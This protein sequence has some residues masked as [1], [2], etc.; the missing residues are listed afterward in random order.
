ME[1]QL[2]LFRQVAVLGAGVMGAQIAA[3][4]ANAGFPVVL[5]D[6]A[7]DGPDKT[8]QV[9]AALKRLTK[10]KPAPLANLSTVEAIH[11]ATYE[12][13]LTLLSRC[14]LIIEAIAEREDLKKSLYEKIAPHI[15]DSAVLATNTSGLSIESLAQYLPEKMRERFCGVHFFNPPRYMRLVELIPHSKTHLALLN[16]LETCL[17]K[18]AG[19]SVVRAKD[20]PN[21]IA[22]RIGVFSALSIFAHATRL[23][24]PP[25]VV[26]ALTGLVI[27]RPKSATYRTLDVVGLDTMAHV[28]GTMQTQLKDD[29]WHEHFQLPAWCQQ[30][31]DK[32]ALGQKAGRGVYLKEGKT[33]RVFDPAN[34]DYRDAKPEIN[35]NVQL[36]LSEK[37][38]AKRFEQLRASDEPQA[39][40]LWHIFL[41]LFHYCAYQLETIADNVR[42]VDLALRWGWGWQ[43]GPFE[44]WQMIGWQSVV[45]WCEE[46]IAKGEALSS[47]ALPFWIFEVESVYEDGAAFSPAQKTT[48]KR[49]DLPVY[50][51]QLAPERVLTQPPV[52]GMGVWEN[53]DARLWHFGDNVGVLSFKT[54]LN[55]VNEGVLDAIMQS[56]Q[57]A[58]QQFDALVVWQTDPQTFSAGANLKA[59]APLFE[60]K[61]KAEILRIV[62][63]FQEAMTALRYS[64][65][66]T[67]AAIR[68]RALGGGCELAMHCDLRVAA[69]ES[70]IGLVEIGVGLIPAGG[71]LKE[72]ARRAFVE[73]NGDDP[74]HDLMRYYMTVAKGDV[75]MSALDAKDKGYLHS[76]DP[77]VMND[78]EVLFVAKE[79]AKAKAAA[80][81]RP[82]L[83]Q[84]VAVVGEGA[85][86]MLQMQLVNLRE[87][88]FISDYDFQIAEQMAR[89]ICGA[90][91]P[92]GTRVNE[93]WFFRL[94]RETFAD[95]ACQELTQARV[96]HMLETGKPLRN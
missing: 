85:M 73:A 10:L 28:I 26:D 74:F 34:N 13:D 83:N 64:L 17:V 61:D 33:I 68:G 58:E 16:V 45:K 52:Q 67:V 1:K 39:Q 15:H 21:F 35:A 5:F 8:A 49:S 6:L 92:A 27:G 80:G 54:P 84:P 89:V 90:E 30:L 24:I 9:K 62:S 94:E 91:L 44:L 2:A 60:Q 70:Y 56:V 77:I 46:D 57:I 3:H 76:D 65:V 87:G 95:L 32:G 93:E 69:M 36:I 59:F 11:P 81:Y 19:K 41:D 14:D 20:T 78:H 79:M 88:K 75:A 71:G 31:I 12:H 18:Q 51:R 50:Q 72:F 47:Q 29:P 53:D 86:A 7:A 63:K 4:F 43:M 38:M 22:N 37:D 25:D 55:T 48:V 40:F 96:K 42:D 66:P 82:P 23:Q